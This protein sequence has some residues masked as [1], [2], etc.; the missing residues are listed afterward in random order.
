MGRLCD[1]PPKRI[2]QK[3]PAPE[4]ET[5]PFDAIP[6]HV[7]MLNPNAIDRGHID[8]VRDRVRPL[9][10]LPGIVLRCP[11]LLFLVGMPANS[12]R[13]KQHI[14]SLQRGDACTLRI[15]L[16]PA[17]QRA[18]LPRRRIERAKTQVAG[19]EIELLVVQRI[20]RD[21]HF[22]VQSR[23]RSVIFENRRRVVIEPRGAPLEQRRY[24][25]DLLLPCH[26]AQL[27]RARPGNRLGQIEQRDILALTKI[28]RA[29]QLRQADDIR[30]LPRRLPHALRGLLQIG[31]RIRSAAHLHQ[32]DA[33]FA[34]FCHICIFCGYTLR[35]NKQK[36]QAPWPTPAS[37]PP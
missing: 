34:F 20:V 25:D 23:N 5:W 22:A 18:N 16:V 6:A 8:P 31:V 21:V 19:R 13:I 28:L 32:P 36:A 11:V 12:R 14:G 7:A 24:D 2:S 10:R 9:N 3:R 29:K 33:K 35:G 27:L 1:H 17:H 4:R 37:F 15:P 30:A 26:R